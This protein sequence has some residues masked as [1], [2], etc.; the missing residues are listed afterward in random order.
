MD[1]FAVKML[2]E[3]D[4][5]TFKNVLSEEVSASKEDDEITER[6][7]D[8]LAKIKDALGDKVSKVK[9]STSIGD[10]AVCLSSEGE[11]S[12]EME[13]VLNSMPGAEEKVKANKVLELNSNHA[14]YAKLKA[15]YEENADGLADYADV[16]YQAGRLISGLTVEDPTAVTD[17]LFALLAK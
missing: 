15:V 4:G 7:K 6:D 13:K 3:Y 16:L 11:V 12:L 17:K 8:M 5:K 9:V 14:L 10:H 1:E 2:G